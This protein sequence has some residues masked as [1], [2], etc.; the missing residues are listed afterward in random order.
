MVAL[1]PC[2]FCGETERL[3]ISEGGFM[4]LRWGIDASGQIRRNERGEPYPD[5]AEEN[6]CEDGVSCGVCEALVPLR[7][8]NASADWLAVMRA[9]VLSADAEFDDDGVWLGQRA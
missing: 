6:G 1:N 8:W 3:T 4:E 2:R 7:V 5:C 9:S